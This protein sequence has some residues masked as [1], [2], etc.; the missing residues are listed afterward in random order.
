MV[1]AMSVSCCI[2]HKGLVAALFAELCILNVMR[3]VPTQMVTAS[4]APFPFAARTFSASHRSVPVGDVSAA[5]NTHAELSP[6]TTTVAAGPVDYL[7]RQFVGWAG[8]N[9]RSPKSRLLEGLP[10]PIQT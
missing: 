9:G 8:S 4:P 2:K 7:V 5:A 6:N 1:T 3:T 10:V